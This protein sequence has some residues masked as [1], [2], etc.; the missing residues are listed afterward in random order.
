MSALPAPDEAPAAT[1]AGATAALAKADEAEAAGRL[2][3]AIE[4]LTAE[5]LRARSPAIEQRLLLLRH[6]AYRPNDRPVIAEWPVP[7]PDPFPDVVGIPEITPDQLTADV[8][9]GSIL[10]HGS[11]IVRGLLPPDRVDEYRAGIDS[12]FAAFDD[13]AARDDAGDSSVDPEGPWFQIFEPDPPYSLGNRRKWVR[14]GGAVWAAESPRMAFDLIENFRRAGVPEVLGEYFGEPPVLSV[15][16]LT[17]RLVGPETQPTWHQDGAFL[18]DG[19]RAFNIWTTLSDCGEDLPIA[20]LDIV[21]KRIPDILKTGTWG[22]W[23]PD[24]IA[25]KVV[26]KAAGKKSIVRPRFAA[27]DALLFDERLVHRTGTSPGMT[28]SRYAVESWFFPPS[29]FPPDYVPLAF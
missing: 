13:W 24:S 20:G 25:P 9:G 17:V 2:W 27:G 14:K 12:T 28:D 6:R 29:S 3:D 18:G 19:V 15:N 1:P 26:A 11:L 4:L 8:L 22:T 7:R 23:L 10:H 16:K 21:S 5:N